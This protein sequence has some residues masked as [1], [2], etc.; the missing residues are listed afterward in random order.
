MPPAIFPASL[1]PALSKT[2]GDHGARSL[3]QQG[4]AVFA[5]EAM[6]ADVDTVADLASLSAP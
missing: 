3:L 4:V 6:L 1:F 2:T 5:D